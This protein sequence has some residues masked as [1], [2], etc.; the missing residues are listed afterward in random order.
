MAARYR[1][2]HRTSY[3]YA[4]PVALS[5]NQAR[6]QPRDGEGQR[7][8]ATDL[9]I[10][11]TPDDRA[12]HEDWFGNAVVHFALQAPHTTLEVAATSEVEVARAA[13][14]ADADDATVE[15]VVDRVRHGADGEAYRAREFRLDSPLLRRLA[16]RDD[17]AG[18]LG[19]TLAPERPALVAVLDLN[20]RIHT[21][22]AY[23]PEA[24]DVATPLTDVLRGRGGVCQDFAH[25]AVAACRARGLAARYVSGYLETQPAD[26]GAKLRGA[27]ASHA[28]FAVYL[29]ALG[30]VELDPT[31]D[32]VVADQHVTAAVGRDYSD[33]PPLKGVI[34]SGGGTTLTV[35]VDVDRVR[36]A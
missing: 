31:N 15:A 26:G 10:T 28:W 17:L 1:V 2:Q 12:E 16:V 14:P 23:D 5:A 27:D 8:I 9:R 20:H 29:P 18:W 34:V 19:D 36:G 35:A 21:E 25:V 32:L 24:T 7:L 33:V 3:Q 13:V 22:F 30:W 6:L 4:E 11:P